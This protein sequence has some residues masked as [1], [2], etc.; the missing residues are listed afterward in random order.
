MKAYEDILN[1]SGN[2]VGTYGR[3]ALAAAG[4]FTI[5]PAV[6]GAW[7]ATHPRVVSFVLEKY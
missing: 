7:I 3:G 2:K 6:I 5:N 1:A 4:A